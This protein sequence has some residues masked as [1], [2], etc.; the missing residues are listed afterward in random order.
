MKT[1]HRLSALIGLL[2]VLV[3]PASAGD[4]PKAGPRTQK[5][6]R[7]ITSTDRNRPEP[8]RGPMAGGEKEVV[9][10]LGVQATPASRT[11]AVQLSL[12]PGAGLVVNHVMPDSPAAGVLQEHDI[13]LKLDDQLLI[14]TRQLSVLIRQH[15]EGDEVGLT[16]LRGGKEATA[17]IKLGKQE[18]P[19]MSGLFEHALP[20]VPHGVLGFGAGRFEAFG[21]DTPREEVDR[22]LSLIQREPHGEPMRIQ[23]DRRGGPGMNA[24]SVH[25]SN[26]NLVYSDDAGSLELTIKDGQKSL[27]AKDG[28]GKE[29]FSG[30]VNTPDERRTMPPEVRARLEKLE[31]MHNITFRTGPDFKGPERKV[32]QPFGRGI[33]LPPAPPAQ[34]RPPQF[35]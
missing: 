7:V 21:P 8:R 27:V 19:K 24:T 10:F 9:A 28:G 15:K 32:V 34:P 33:S 6:M 22:V 2:A 30:P 20:G 26:S 1:S 35:F 5:E 13:L 3:P 4:A 14:E 25:T 12:P 17:H 31:G 16:Y 18:V 23:I 29:I 11:L